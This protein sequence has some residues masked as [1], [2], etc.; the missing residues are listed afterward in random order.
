VP[1]TSIYS[2]SDGVVH[3]R[4]SVQR[5]GE[6]SENIEVSAS[7]FGIGFNPLALYA[8]ADRL[9]QPE[10]RWRPFR[11]EGLQ[12]VFFRQPQPE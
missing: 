11:R 4:C 3:W 1:F 5:H 12:G 8:V 7:H 2:R 10:G 6:R 9:A